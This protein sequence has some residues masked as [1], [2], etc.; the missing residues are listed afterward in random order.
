MGIVKTVLPKLRAIIAVTGILLVSVIASG[1]IAFLTTT[2]TTEPLTTSEFFL[3][4]AL[5]FLGF[6]IGGLVYVYFS[7]HSMSSY[8]DIN[9]VVSQSNLVTGIGSGIA[10]SVIFLLFSSLATFLNIP[11]IDVGDEL[12]INGELNRVIAF[13]FIVLLFNAPAEEFLYR[14]IIQKRLT[15]SFRDST[16]IIIATLIFMSVHIPT[17]LVAGDLSTHGVAGM[18]FPLLI[19]TLLGGVLGWVYYQTEDLWVPIITHA[20]Y[21]VSQLAVYVF[22][23]GLV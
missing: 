8:I 15:A 16:G 6:V 21:N 22:S 9:G 11:V 17:Y 13:I 19:I 18:V 2:I 12:G 23:S 7:N 1:I 14:N 5:P 4:T 3:R 10:C 20:I